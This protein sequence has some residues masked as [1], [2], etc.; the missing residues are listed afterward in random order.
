MGSK[1]QQILRQLKIIAEMKK[2]N[3]PNTQSISRL[4]VQN[5]DE[6]GEPMGCSSR[7]IMRDIQQLQQE[8]QAPIEYDSTNK[9]YFLRDPSWQFKC[10]V[11]EEDF[12]SMS[13][14]GTRLA[15]DIVP[16]PLKT[17]IDNAV[18]QTLATNSSDF[19][20]AAMI[21][22]ILCA[23]GVKASI[24]PDVFMMLFNAWRR[25]QAV[26]LKYRDPQGKESEYEFEP[27][28]IAFHKG[29]WYLK[30]YLYR[31][32][33][34]R[35]FACQ[36]ITEARRN[37]HSYETD[38]KLLEDTRRK[39]L[40]NYPKVSGI[41]LHCDASIAFYI[42]EQQNL[43]NSKIERQPD[44]SLIVTLNPTVEHDVVRWILGEAGRIQVIEPQSLRERIAEAGREITR[45]NS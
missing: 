32:K 31:T 19:F 13:I 40:F 15:E 35:L 1:A 29:N 22:S 34:L 21:D 27:H 30:G 2:G 11:F 8:F 38:R 6:F 23:S 36:R 16:E 24:N 3:Y 28:I 10:P 42:Y 43:F 25:K 5:E 14:L 17:D 9:G 20:D 41:K 37:G 44:D 18:S 26:I 12:V 7:T 45:R 33:E 39:G 4:F